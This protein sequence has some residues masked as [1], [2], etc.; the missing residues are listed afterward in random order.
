MKGNPMKYAVL[1]AL[2]MAACAEPGKPVSRTSGDFGLIEI[3]VQ[4]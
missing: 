3:T 4:A 1:L 2:A